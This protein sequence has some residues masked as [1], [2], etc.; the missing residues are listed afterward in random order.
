MVVAIHMFH[1]FLNSMISYTCEMVKKC[2]LITDFYQ[3][4]GKG[5]GVTDSAQKTKG[6][7]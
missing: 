7:N 3:C 4:F 1:I 6:L 2:Y 5:E